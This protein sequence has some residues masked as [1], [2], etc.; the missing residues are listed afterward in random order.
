VIDDCKEDHWAPEI[1]VG[2]AKSKCGDTWFPTGAEAIKCVESQTKVVDDCDEALVSAT[3]ASSGTCFDGKVTAIAQDKCGNTADPKKVDVLIDNEPPSVACGFED[4]YGGLT[5]MKSMYPLP[6]GAETLRDQ[7]FVYVAND[8]CGGAVEVKVD[9]FA[10]ELE[11]F[12]DPKMA[13]LYRNGNEND[14]ADLYI[15]E[16]FCQPNTDEAGQCLQDPNRLLIHPLPQNLHR[17]YTIEVT[18]T[19]LAGNQAMAVCMV[20]VIQWWTNVEDY[21]FELSEQRFHLQSYTTSF[22]YVPPVPTS[23]PVSAPT[24]SPVSD[25]T[26]SPVSTVKACS[27]CYGT[28]TGPCQQTNTVCQPLVYGVCPTGSYPC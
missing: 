13:L 18:A 25:P 26:S 4:G 1:T 10:N 19:D 22:A 9:V 2:T 12:H 24:S 8:S 5:T 14:A 17:L 3:F 21:K 7:G 16:A 15:S 11:E 20:K 27:G 28:S 6:Y 23:T